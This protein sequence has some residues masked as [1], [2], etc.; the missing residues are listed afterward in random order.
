MPF[1]NLQKE[2]ISFSLFNGVPR[3]AFRAVE[4]SEAFISFL[5]FFFLC[6]YTFNPTRFDSTGFDDPSVS[7]RSAVRREEE[8]E[9]E[10][11]L[12]LRVGFYSLSLQPPPF[13]SSFL[14]ALFFPAFNA[15]DGEQS[16]AGC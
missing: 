1:A 16:S 8:E 9:E 4:N 11:E 6:V 3:R 2:T 10:E 12:P 13:S 7:F 15:T 5:L 14:N